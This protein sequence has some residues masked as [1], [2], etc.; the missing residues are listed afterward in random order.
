MVNTVLDP[1]SIESRYIATINVYSL[2]YL[3]CKC[4]LYLALNVRQ[5]MHVERRW[6]IRTHTPPV[7]QCPCIQMNWKTLLK[8]SGGKERY[9]FQLIM[10][11]DFVYS[12]GCT[13]WLTGICFHYFFLFDGLWEVKI[14]FNTIWY[15]SVCSK[16]FCIF[17]IYLLIRITSCFPR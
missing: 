14:A 11:Y 12:S 13:H 10:D 4:I 6:H 1:S 16:I 15:Q 3:Q 5:L 8:F 17:G 9:H 7:N 2:P